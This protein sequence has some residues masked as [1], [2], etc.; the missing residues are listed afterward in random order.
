MKPASELAKLIQE[1]LDSAKKTAS[2]LSREELDPDRLAE[3]MNQRGETFAALQE[4]YANAVDT[5]ALQGRDERID[6]G[7]KELVDE[8]MALDRSNMAMMEQ[9]LKQ[10]R[11]DVSQVNL[12]RRTLTAYGWVDPVHGPK[13]AFIDRTQG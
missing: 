5:G 13:G 8:L 6:S 7:L 3:L 10:L 11:G 1:L 9:R 4:A 2:E 12:Q